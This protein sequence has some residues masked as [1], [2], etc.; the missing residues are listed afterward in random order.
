MWRSFLKD[1]VWQAIK[2]ERR[3]FVRLFFALFLL[4]LSQS[5]LVLTLG[6]LLKAFFTGEGELIVLGSMFSSLPGELRELSVTRSQLAQTIPFALLGLGLCRAFC[7][8]LFN[9][10]QQYLTLEVTA[11]FRSSL[12][13]RILEARYLDGAKRSPAEWMSVIMNDVTAIEG[14]LHNLVTGFLRDLLTLVASYIGLIIVWWPAAVFLLLISPFVA[15][16]TGKTGRK[17]SRWSEEFQQT[18]AKFQA[19]AH[20]YRSRLEFVQAQ[21]GEKRELE[22]FEKLNSK[23]FIAVK[24]SIFTRALFAPAF[25]FLGF[26]LFAGVI[27]IM[28]MIEGFL[29]GSRLITFFVALGLIFKPLRSLGEQYVGFEQMRGLLKQSLQ[30]LQL[31]SSIGSH[32]EAPSQVFKQLDISLLKIKYSKFSIDLQNFSFGAGQMVLLSGPSGAGKSS[33][34]KVLA[35]LVDPNEF[36]SNMA[37]EDLRAQVSYVGQIPFLFK[38]TLRDNL[39]YGLPQPAGDKDLQEALEWA[40]VRR[41][42][43]ELGGLGLCFDPL[44][45]NLSGGQVQRLV[46]ARGFLR[47]ATILAFDEST[48]SLD[49]QTERE[50]LSS[51]KKKAVFESKTILVVSHRFELLDM[52]DHVYFFENGSIALQGKVDEITKKDRFLEF[53][54]GAK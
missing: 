31:E 19:F 38:G 53:L 12:F 23:Y 21:K 3:S 32:R 48:A 50:V 30:V 34:L 37:L 4:G 28:P 51:L 9:V 1:H 52:F 6:P 20:D 44:T 39:N 47:R 45:P 8:Y 2:N 22:Q 46:I 29:E 43:D 10:E 35:G 54:E 17:I 13:K 5:G 33:I 11:K 18:Q 40:G 49:L 15:I 7:S 25:E 27:F 16:W 26:S 42:I 24:K 36:T 41:E 14:K